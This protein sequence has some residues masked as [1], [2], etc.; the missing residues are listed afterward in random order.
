MPGG[1]V[2]KKPVP[3]AV[4]TRAVPP[5][6]AAPAQPS[7]GVALPSAAPAQVGAAAGPPVNPAPLPTAPPTKPVVATPPAH[8]SGGPKA[9]GQNAGGPNASGQNPAGNDSG[10]HKPGSNAPSAIGS[11]PASP[12]LLGPT[13]AGPTNTAPAASGLTGTASALPSNPLAAQ[14]VQAGPVLSGPFDAS[15][16]GRTPSAGRGA[17]DPTF[18]TSRVKPLAINAAPPSASACGAGASAGSVGPY[19]GNCAA[20]L[21]GGVISTSQ[22]SRDLGPNL[23]GP[24]SI[25]AGPGGSAQNGAVHGGGGFDGFI[26]TGPLA[27]TGLPLTTLL[28][29]FVLIALGLVLQRRRADSEG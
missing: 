5:V 8:N 25:A 9:G 13:T 26:G 16:A 24:G 20:D 18:S 15:T 27:S 19:S 3:A 7:T 1:P 2:V 14:S 12:A 21:V 17:S 4:T 23:A 28:L 10:G 22:V 6:T 11:V 29:A